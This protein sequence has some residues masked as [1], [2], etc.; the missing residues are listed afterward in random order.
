MGWLILHA[1]SDQIDIDDN[2]LYG[3]VGLMLKI[4]LVEKLLTSEKYL[5]NFLKA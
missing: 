1:L 5:F 4:V 3:N 2:G